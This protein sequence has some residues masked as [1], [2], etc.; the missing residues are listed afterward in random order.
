MEILKMLDKNITTK[1][2]KKDESPYVRTIYKN[3]S[4]DIAREMEQLKEMI[5]K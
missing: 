5:N 3:D 4:I 1:K 2:Y